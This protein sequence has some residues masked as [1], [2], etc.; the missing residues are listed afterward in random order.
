MKW[1]VDGNKVNNSENDEEDDS[2]GGNGDSKQSE[3]WGSGKDQDFF[4]NNLHIVC[5]KNV[6]LISPWRI[7]FKYLA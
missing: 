1:E 4:Q 3:L 2:T 5:I 7:S 6:S